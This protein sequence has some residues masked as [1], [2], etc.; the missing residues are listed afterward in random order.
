MMMADS[1]LIK[2]PFGM[3]LE[4]FHLTISSYNMHGFNSGSSFLNNLC[5]ENDFIFIQEH[6]LLSQHLSNLSNFRQDFIFHGVSA[7]DTV[8]SQGIL[9]G[10]PFGGVGVLIRKSLSKFTSVCGFHR[11]NR[12]VA[13][14]FNRG[15][16]QVICVGLYFPSDR[17]NLQEYVD[18]LCSINGF[19]ESVIDDNPG[20]KI[21]LTGD[22]NFPCNV[23]DKGY[24]LFMSLTNDFNLTS[25]DVLDVEN[26]GY[27]YFHET[28]GHKSFIDHFL[29]K[30][31]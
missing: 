22:F 4:N 10:R 16:L 23:G 19:I 6:W 20:Y 21:L 5:I 31:I 30:I 25:C 28:L 24:D 11:D 17:N 8:S 2:P 18:S 15:D 3:A 29:F 1:S 9:R 27:T 26:V 14:K 12:A 13:I 7:M